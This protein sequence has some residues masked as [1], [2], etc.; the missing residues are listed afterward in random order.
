MRETEIKKHQDISR[1]L[2][3]VRPQPGYVRG[4][5]PD[6]P[7][8]ETREKCD[9]KKWPS[10]TLGKGGSSSLGA[11]H[12]IRRKGKN[13]RRVG[14]CFL[15]HLTLNGFWVSSA[16]GKADARA[17]ELEKRLR[18][19]E[20]QPVPKDLRA[21]ARHWGLQSVALFRLSARLADVP[22]WPGTAPRSR[23]CSAASRGRASGTASVGRSG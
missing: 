17:E 12:A 2:P 15:S 23:R 18:H 4:A 5:V 3:G 20:A 19:M 6:P 13:T 7:G 11:A 14:E 1:S 22:S 9:L 10:G 16:F 21:S 8:N